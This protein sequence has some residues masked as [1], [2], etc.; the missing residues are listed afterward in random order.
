MKILL[1]VMLFSHTAHAVNVSYSDLQ[2]LILNCLGESIGESSE[3]QIE[4]ARVVLKRAQSKR[5]PSSVEDVVYQK[6]QFS[7]VGKGIPDF[8]EKDVN[9][10]QESVKKAILLGPGQFSHYYAVSGRYKIEAPYWT[11]AFSRSK[12]IGNH[13]FLGE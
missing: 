8:T 1:L 2:A 5:W 3:G 9:K 13:K 6:S 7:W 4:V 11:K 12:V 10:C